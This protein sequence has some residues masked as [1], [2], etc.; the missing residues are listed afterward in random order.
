MELPVVSVS[1]DERAVRKRYA[2]TRIRTI[3]L[4]L[5]PW[6]YYEIRLIGLL[7]ISGRG[8]TLAKTVGLLVDAVHGDVEPVRGS[9]PMVSLNPSGALVVSAA[10]PPEQRLAQAREAAFRFGARY[11]WVPKTFEVIVHRECYRPF[12]VLA[13]DLKGRIDFK[14]LDASTG[15][16][17]FKLRDR[18][19]SSLKNWL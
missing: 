9:L 10:L 6:D 8:L 17:D 1:L 4:V 5:C 18:L 11:L 12:W 14:V 19:I 3:R 7:G 2:S 13:G 16:P 15:R